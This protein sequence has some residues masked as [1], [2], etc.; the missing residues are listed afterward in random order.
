MCY[1]HSW[2]F[3]AL[4]PNP[5]DICG[6]DC[7]IMSRQIHKLTAL[8]IT[9]LKEPG[10]H[11]D[12]GGL[13]MRVSASGN[14]SWAFR[15]MLHGKAREMGLGALHTVSLLDART[16][17]AECRKLVSDGLDPI[18]AREV[19]FHALRA[20][21]SKNKPF[22]ECAQ[23][24]VEA[25]KAS[26]KNQKHVSQW[27]NTLKEYAYPIL[28]DVPI[29]KVDTEHI[30]DVL[31]PIWKTKTETAS[32]LRGRMEAILDWAAVKLYRE[33]PNPARWKG[34]LKFQLPLPSKVKK[35]KHHPALPYDELPDFMKALQSDN[36]VAALALQFT[37]LTVARTS[38]TLL[39]DWTEVDL[40]KKTWIVPAAKIKAERD[41]RVPL[42]EA[43][44]EVLIQMREITGGK[45]LVFPGR[46]KGRPLS[47]MA[48]LKVLERLKR[49]DITVH[50]FR[51]TFRDWAAEQTNFPPSVAEAAL[52]HAVGDKTEAAYLR[53]DH[54]E[55]RRQ[56]MIAWAE[57]SEKTSVLQPRNVLSVKE[58]K[59]ARQA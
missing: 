14:K 36:G 35:V 20:Q 1:Y 28:G 15:F 33:G 45:G 50:G 58:R 57:L 26:W 55:K 56:V 49:D 31:Q 2:A 51:S 25:H 7:G 27:E 42:S 19:K 13:Y 5:R 3:G 41:H 23:E 52:A 24:Y 6:I 8:S 32:R 38:E 9:K 59:D 22:K 10:L 11:G 16:K 47:N 53:T 29:R 43:A 39:M 12:G 37:I 40:K 18:D 4:P 48:M 54:F 34:H 46:K 44:I 30:L 17:A 21:A